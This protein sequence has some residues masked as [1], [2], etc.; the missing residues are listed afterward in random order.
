MQ[1]LK[2]YNNKNEKKKRKENDEKKR[3]NKDIKQWCSLSIL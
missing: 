2:Y 3:I 1:L